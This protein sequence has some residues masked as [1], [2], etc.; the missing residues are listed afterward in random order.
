[1]QQYLEANPAEVEGQTQLEGENYPIIKSQAIPNG[2]A[3][4]TSSFEAS[5]T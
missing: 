4:D 3:W 5:F 1:M 2:Y